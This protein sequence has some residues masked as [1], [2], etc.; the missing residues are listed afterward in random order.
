MNRAMQIG[1]E[2]AELRNKGVEWRALRQRFGHGVATLMRWRDQAL[3]LPKGK[4]PR[5]Y[6]RLDIGPPI[7]REPADDRHEFEARDGAEKLL[8][9]LREV[10]PGGFEDAAEPPPRGRIMAPGPLGSV[11]GCTAAWCAAEGSG[12]YGTRLG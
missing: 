4:K 11:T 7:G 1:R 3:G 8:R 10:H 6:E 12:A 5:H 9:R 2:V